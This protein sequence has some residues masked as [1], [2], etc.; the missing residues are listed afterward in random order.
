MPAILGQTEFLKTVTRRTGKKRWNVGSI[1]E[2]KTNY[3]RD[4]L[5]AHGKIINVYQEDLFNMTNEDAQKEGYANLEDFKKIAWI[6]ING[7]WKNEKVWVVEFQVVEI[8]PA[9]SF[10]KLSDTFT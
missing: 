3:N 9:P 10:L 2:F 5:F 8:T 4:S 7:E 6:D 1:H